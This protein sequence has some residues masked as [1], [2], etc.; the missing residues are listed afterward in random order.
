MLSK[1]AKNGKTIIFTIHQPSSRL[2]NMLDRLI[3][4]NHG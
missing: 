4:L 1:I 2:F 3:L